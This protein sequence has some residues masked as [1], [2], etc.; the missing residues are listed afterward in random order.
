[1][2]WLFVFCLLFLSLTQSKGQ[3]KI[4]VNVYKLY[5]QNKAYYLQ[6]IPYDYA[7][8]TL[9]GITH[10]FKT[11]ES[12]P[13]YSINRYFEY[14]YFPNLVHLSNDGQSLVYINNFFHHDEVDK[15]N[16]ITFYHRGELSKTHKM[17]DLNGCND[18]LQDCK[19]LYTNPQAYDEEA[20]K[21]QDYQRILKFHRSAP[22]IER[23][24]VE[25][26]A[27]SHEDTLYLIDQSKTVITLDLNS[28]VLLKKSPL[29]SS[30]SKLKP[31]ARINYTEPL[32]VVTPSEFEMPVLSRGQK[33]S[34]ALEVYLDMKE[35]NIPDHEFRW[36]SIHYAVYQSTDGKMQI[37]KLEANDEL[38]ERKL[39]VF[40]TTLTYN[41]DHI[42]EELGGW[43]FT[44]TLAFRHKSDSIARWE[45]EQQRIKWAKEVKKLLVA[46]SIDGF[47]IPRNLEESIHEL[48]KILKPKF[49]ELVKS[50]GFLPT[51]LA[52]NFRNRWQLWGNSRLKQYFLDR[53]PHYEYMPETIWSIIIWNYRDWLNGD[54]EIWKQWEKEN[55]IK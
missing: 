10:V 12:K 44:G 11:G 16:T 3:S 21:Y 13:L 15:Y 29:D 5:S 47:Y 50:K 39:E 25:F 35:T 1:M 34:E 8:N 20:T 38:L 2:K 26:N 51:S 19:L 33:L 18:D 14:Y 7:Y 32:P 37:E 53:Q 27:L 9:Y 45:K 40:L 23:F 17:V 24:A 43:R 46:D 4:T 28:G 30:F 42:P 22:S 49:K 6:S 54:K 55:P 52:R 48:D 36:Y 31:L 41:S